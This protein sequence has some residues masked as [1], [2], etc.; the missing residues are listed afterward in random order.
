MTILLSCQSKE[1]IRCEDIAALNSL[2]NSGEKYEL[3]RKA[4]D[5]FKGISVYNSELVSLDG[6]KNL[7]YNLSGKVT[8]LNFWFTTCKPCIEEIPYFNELKTTFKDHD[9]TFISLA[10]NK[11][12]TVR[13]FLKKTP[14]T[15]DAYIVDDIKYEYCVSSYPTTIVLDKDKKII[16]YAIGGPT[17]PAALKKNQEDL[18][19][20]ILAHI[21]S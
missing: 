20:L 3:L 14:F 5:N 21:K 17:D 12:E 1:F 8:V 11:P 4:Y 7:L 13:A 18:K 16:K 9:V 15:W 19:A 2:E 6:D 10:L